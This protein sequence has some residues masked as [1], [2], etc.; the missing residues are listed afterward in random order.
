MRRQLRHGALCVLL[1]GTLLSIPDQAQNSSGD[2]QASDTDKAIQLR[3]QIEEVKKN[4]ATLEEQLAAEEQRKHEE[5]AAAEAR[6]RQEQLAAEEKMSQPAQAQGPPQAAFSVDP[7][8]HSIERTFGL[9]L[10]ADQ[11]SFWTSPLR[12]RLNDAPSLFPFFAVTAA[13]VASDDSIEQRLPHS[14]TLIQHSRSLSSYGVASLFTAAG[15]LYL[16]GKKA[17]DDHAQETGFLAGEAAIDSLVEAEAIKF[18]AGRERPLQGNGRGRFWQGGSS[19]PSEHAAAAWSIASIL[20]HEYPGPLTELLAYGAASGI[21]AAR[22]IGR[23]HFAS[24]AL[25][26]SA[27]GWYAGRQ[28][29]RSHH[30]P[31]LNGAE[32]GT[33]ERSHEPTQARDMG[34]PYV[35]LDSWVY[36][37]FDRLVAMGYVQTG[38]AGLK[39]WTRME[40]AR[41]LQ[42]AEGL[43]QDDGPENGEAVRLYR[44][45]RNEFSQEVGL[46][47]GGRN[48]GAEVESVYTRSTEISG[49]PLTDGY[50]FG[51]TIYNDFGR[52]YAEGFNQITGTSTRAEAGPFA[53]YFRGE[54][55]HAPA[56][57]VLPLNVQQAIAA[58]DLNPLVP[59]GP[60]AVTNRFQLLDSYVAVNFKGLQFSAGQESL[61][62]GPGQSGSLIWSNNAEPIPMVRI[63]QNSPIKLPGFLSRLGPVRSEFFFGRLERDQSPSRAYVH[64]QTIAIKFNPNLEFGYTRTVVF[65]ISPEPLTWG[66][67]FTSLVKTNSGSPSPLYKPGKQLNSLEWTYRIPGLRNWVMFTGNALES[68]YPIAF[69]APR[70]AAMNP[71]IY[72]PQ[73]PKI[74]K[75]DL[76]IEAVYT[77]VPSAHNAGNGNFDY[78]DYVYHN[79]Y[80]N[81]GNLLGN[82][83]GRDGI[84]IQAWSTY[85]LSPRSTLQLNFR[86]ATVSKDFLQGGE[87]NDFGARADLLIRPQLSLASSLQYEQWD[88]PLL[89]PTRNSNFTASLQFTYWPKW[90]TR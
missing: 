54:Y 60:P 74:R 17:G 26:G 56:L 15:G 30:N 27:L 71:G 86:R 2:P 41:L 64:G 79:F 81:N 48:V 55:Q 69:A 9:N 84:G 6:R 90:R 59:A 10:A 11:K 4:L 33:F 7:P 85:W 80:T 67:F 20:A 3:K 36:P 42:E 50:H 49:P 8:H 13:T 12:L 62:Y 46:L 57:P 72:M 1:V 44:G 40:C 38:F 68:E 18:M 89:S 22:V 43:M 53:F 70:R 52:P 34:S 24:D 35:P 29:Y 16:W 83:I 73:F 37:L 61:S 19:F 31:E 63:S 39:P 58:A 47:E 14:P 65:A 51:Q 21:T 23:E 25:V 32:W 76:R 78:W 66:T 5:E 28:V 87:Y 82:W 75:L 88:F 45:L 77:N